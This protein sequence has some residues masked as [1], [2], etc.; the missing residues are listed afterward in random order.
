MRSDGASLSCVG[1]SLP[2]A[3]RES[4]ALLIAREQ[5]GGSGGNIRRSKP[6]IQ[7]L[8]GASERSGAAV[9]TVLISR[10]V[11]HQH[12]AEGSLMPRTVVWEPLMLV[13]ANLTRLGRPVT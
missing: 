13:R 6:R 1:D 3:C 8:P 5:A 4:S 9:L 12:L 10:T 2:F 11:V 7:V